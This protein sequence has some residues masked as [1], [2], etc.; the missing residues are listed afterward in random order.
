MKIKI[1]LLELLFFLYEIAAAQTPNSFAKIAFE[2]LNQHR[3]AAGLS[4]LIRDPILDLSATA[5]ANYITGNSSI[6]TE[7][8]LEALGKKGFSGATPDQRMR[9][10][11]YPSVDSNENYSM[12]SFPA[13]DI[14]TTNLIDAPYHRESQLGAF[15]DAGVGMSAQKAPAGSV[16]REQYVYVI[17]FGNKTSFK[18]PANYL[19]VYPI[20][21]QKNVTADWVVNESPNPLPEM[22]GK[23]VGYPI[24]IATT[25]SNKLEVK[26]FVLFANDQTISEARLITTNVQSQKKL[27]SYAFLIPIKPLAYNSTYRAQVIGTLNG[28]D[29]S[30]EWSFTTREKTALKLISSANGL[31]GENKS[32]MNVEI[33][34]GTSNGYA[35]YSVRQSFNIDDQTTTGIGI[36]L[37]GI[38]YPRPGAVKLIRSATPCAYPIS[39]C[40]LIISGKDSSGDEVSLGLPIY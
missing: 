20:Q 32:E 31:S 17:N 14:S 36:S 16:N 15:K 4:E 29:F 6:K 28:A 3:Q 13:G 10:F 26:S 5:H 2:E 27:G 35:I 11:G 39:E 33:S 12:I 22:D 1:Y 40:E 34:G 24:S 25:P 18:T 7:G 19:F 30:K 9:K 21:N 23:R 8:H 38:E 37:Y